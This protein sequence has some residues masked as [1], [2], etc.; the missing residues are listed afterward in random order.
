LFGGQHPLD[1]MS[2][3]GIPALIEVRAL[4]DGRRGGL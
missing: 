2:Q 1:V 4:L 3:G